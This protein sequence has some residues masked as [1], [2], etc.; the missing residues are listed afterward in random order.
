VLLSAETDGP[1]P[2]PQVR[3]RT[4]GKSRLGTTPALATVPT[5]SRIQFMTVVDSTRSCTYVAWRIS[6]GY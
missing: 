6:L 1:M 3:T 5:T 4:V 2:M